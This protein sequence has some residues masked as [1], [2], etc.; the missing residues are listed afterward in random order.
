MSRK[1]SLFNTLCAIA[2]VSA[3][4]GC[5]DEAEAE[6]QYEAGYE[7]GYMEAQAIGNQRIDELETAIEDAISQLES[8]ESEIESAKSEAENAANRRSYLTVPD[9]YDVDAMRRSAAEAGDRAASASD[10]INAAKESLTS[11]EKLAPSGA[12]HQ[13]PF[14]SA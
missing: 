4:S 13:P 6:M 1:I 2:I 9:D 12:V 14:S 7:S 8:A 3:L 10:H 11:V 5:N